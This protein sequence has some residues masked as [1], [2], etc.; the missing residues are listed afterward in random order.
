MALIVFLNCVN[1]E[2]EEELNTRIANKAKLLTEKEG[3]DVKSLPVESS[4]TRDA[5]WCPGVTEIVNTHRLNIEDDDGQ[6]YYIL[7]ENVLIQ[8]TAR[9]TLKVRGHTSLHFFLS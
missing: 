4:V 1:C 8:D 3:F 9:E 2:S 5:S 6:L 7:I